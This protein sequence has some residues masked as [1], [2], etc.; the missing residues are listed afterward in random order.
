[1][2]VLQVLSQPQL[3]FLSSLF[4]PDTSTSHGRPLSSLLSPPPAPIS[5][6]S[7]LFPP[8]GT[9]IS[10]ASIEFQY[11]EAIASLSER[12]GT[13]KWFLGSK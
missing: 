12:L 2:H 1:M 10:A 9:H 3:S 5:G 8:Y 7:S 6:I 11:K 13:D 4:T